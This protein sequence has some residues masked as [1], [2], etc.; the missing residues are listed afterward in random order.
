MALMM[1]VRDQ[2]LVL[3]RRGLSYG[4][5]AAELGL[6]RNTV[7]SICQRAGITP[8]QNRQPVTACEHCGTALETTGSGRRFCS[9]SCRL[10]WWHSHPECL[11][12]RAIYTFTCPTCQQGFSAY[13]NARRKYCSHA[14]YIRQRFGTK[15]GRP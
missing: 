2:V 3:R 12:R 9:T 4:Q 1:M 15:G 11:N 7:K 14:C 10:A 13:G 8:E 5:I 6:S